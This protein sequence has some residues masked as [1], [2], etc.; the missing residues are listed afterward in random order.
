MTRPI[1]M[2]HEGNPET[3]FVPSTL[4]AKDDFTSSDTTENNSSFHESEDGRITAGVWECAPCREEFDAYP[5]DEMMT[6]ISG[7]VTLTSPD[8]SVQTF[9]GGDTFFMPKGTSCIWEITETLKKFYM[10]SA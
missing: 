2:T 1:R 5:V 6:V 4:V 10:I 8:G 9:S 7:S 3:G